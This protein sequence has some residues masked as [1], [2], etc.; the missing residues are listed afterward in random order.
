MSTQVSAAPPPPP[1][2]KASRTVDGRYDL[3]RMLRRGGASTVWIATQRSL[4]RKV[5]VKLL[6][7]EASRRD[8][9]TKR[10][11]REAEL[12]AKVRHPNVVEVID[13]GE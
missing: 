4:R 8:E 6:E 10:F 2:R 5:A 9:Y 3:E 12:A 13:T 11:V 1:P 7:T